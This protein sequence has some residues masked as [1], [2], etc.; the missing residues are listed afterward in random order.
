ME[1]VTTEGALVEALVNGEVE[2]NAT[3]SIDGNVATV[4]F[5]PAI[6]TVG[7]AE[8]VFPE[9]VFTISDRRGNTV[10]SENMTYN[11]EITG[12]APEMP[13][14][15]A[16]APGEYKV[17]P[18]VYLTYENATAIEVP[19]GATATLAV[20]SNATYTFDIVATG[21]NKVS[22]VPREEISLYVSQYTTY[23]LKIAKG[24]YFVTVDGKK[25]GNQ[26]ADI[27]DYKVAPRAIE[28]TVDPKQGNY[29]NG[30][31]FE[32]VTLNVSSEGTLSKDSMKNAILYK[33]AEDGTRTQ[34]GKYSGF[35][36]KIVD[37]SVVL[38]IA[39]MPESFEDGE[40][41]LELAQGLFKCLFPGTSSPVTSAKTIYYYTI[42]EATPA[43]EQ[44]YTLE[45][46]AGVYPV[47]P[48]VVVTYTDAAAVQVPSGATATLKVGNNIEFTLDIIPSEN[49]IKIV[50]RQD[51]KAYVNEYTTYSLEVA[52]GTFS[53]VLNGRPWPNTPLTITDYKVAAPVIEF[54]IDPEEGTYADPQIFASLTIT[55]PESYTLSK[56]SMKTANLYKVA[57]DGSR[58]QIGKYSGFKNKV[59][60]NTLVN[61]ITE[62]PADMTDGE[63]QIEIP[64]G[65]FKALMPG[66]TTPVENQLITLTYT[67]QQ[68]SAVKALLE[69]GAEIE[70]YTL[71]GVRL[72][73]KDLKELPAGLYIVNGKKHIVR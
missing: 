39:S 15:L 12:P 7:P 32:T 26:A 61:P 35:K 25:W 63:Y 16:P 67:L 13:F 56:N 31:M 2:A 3:I 8:V 27:T 9:G 28:F 20:G 47:Y 62:L 41:Q 30:N 17:Y 11:C 45:P 43:P 42:G 48:D 6:E 65:F 34:V 52:E 71:Q 40:Y 38:T 22:F 21:S 69:S 58:E 60:G 23:T 44:K 70:V 29:E 19:E 37:R 49:S 24:S 36:T 50:P 10:P 33:V 53:V 72:G 59:E 64:K 4:S 51:I 18:T 54:T 46:E 66:L 14:S 73:A 5:N 68:G 1:K 55:V 57:E